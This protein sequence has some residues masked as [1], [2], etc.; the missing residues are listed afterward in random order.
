MHRF[1]L[2]EKNGTIELFDEDKKH[3]KVLR[4]EKNEL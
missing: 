3:F 2:L 4:I 1:L